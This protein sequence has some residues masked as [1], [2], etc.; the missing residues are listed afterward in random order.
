[1]LILAHLNKFYHDN[2][3]QSIETLPKNEA[4]KQNKTPQLAPGKQQQP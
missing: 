2:S 4:E 1:M 3:N